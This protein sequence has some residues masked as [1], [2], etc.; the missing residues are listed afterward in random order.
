M[1]EIVSC[2]LEQGPKR[3]ISMLEY[4]PHTID[5]KVMRKPNGCTLKLIPLYLCN[6]YTYCDGNAAMF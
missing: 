6:A 1:M 3:C 4:F 2:T 5:L